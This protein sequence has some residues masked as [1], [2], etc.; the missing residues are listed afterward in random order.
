MGQV[1]ITGGLG[2]IGSNLINFLLSETEDIVIVY[3]NILQEKVLKNKTW[4]EQKFPK[5]SRLKIIR[6]NL[7]DS[8]KLKESMVDVEK[9]YHIAG[10]IAVTTSVLDPL[11]D[12]E[13]NAQ[14][15]LNVLENARQLDTDP[16]LILTSTN[17]I[18][19]DLKGISIIE[20]EKRY[21]FE[22]LK[23]GIA[24]NTPPNPYS[25][26]GC[27]KFCADSYFKA[28]SRI[29]GLKTIIFRMSCI[30]GYRQFGT[31]DQGWVAHFIISSLF[32]R[33]FTIYGDGK[34]TRDVLFV[35][36]LIDAFQLAFK[37]IN[38]TKGKAYNIGGG[39]NNTVS[40]LE[41]IHLLEKL[42]NHKIKYDFNDWRPGDQK[43]Y[44]SN[45]NK[46]K[47]DFNWIPQISKEEGIQ[48]L[49]NWVRDNSTLF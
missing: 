4:L 7:R 14:G 11:I 32:N 45:I 31:E 29:Y 18:Y 42:L 47:K 1:L 25:P 26:Y 15:T 46:A 3:D 6:G 44:Y 37:K 20:E 49:F 30:Y 27:S 40:L 34:Q 8:E 13:I 23:Q 12:F 22:K 48:K 33:K 2:F 9:I 21:D 10:Q 43:V 16:C 39:P 35:Q 5:N 38:I 17:K 19:G 24:E 36:D 41:L 28:Y